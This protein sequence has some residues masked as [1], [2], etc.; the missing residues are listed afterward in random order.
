MNVVRQRSCLRLQVSFAR[1]IRAVPP[2]LD[3]V[4]V[5][6]GLVE[7][8]GRFLRTGQEGEGKAAGG[9]KREKSV[10]DVQVSEK[11]R[12]PHAPRFP[13]AHLY[14]GLRLR[15]VNLV[16]LWKGGGGVSRTRRGEREE[17]QASVRLGSLS[18]R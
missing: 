13:V 14:L 18:P 6:D 16:S 2:H 11:C 5:A 8:D 7:L 17:A 12:P 15:H 9:G 10:N 3:L 4:H 1:G